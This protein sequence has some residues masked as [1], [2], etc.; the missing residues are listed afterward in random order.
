MDYRI[1]ETSEKKVLGISRH[2]GGTASERFTAEHILWADDCD[3]IPAKICDGYDGVWYGIWNSGSYI[4]AR[5]EDTVSGFKLETHYIPAGKYAVFTTQRGGFAG[6]ELPELHD[7]IHHAWL[8]N[9][10]YRQV[11][12]FEAEVY[13]LW[14]D[15]AE[16]RENRYDEIEFPMEKREHI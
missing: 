6:D 16:R 13:H 15:R 14:T 7:L 2:I 9:S 4:I 5:A 10:E 1:V 12:D 8:P 11:H 3:H